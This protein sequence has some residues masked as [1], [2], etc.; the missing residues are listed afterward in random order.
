M[1]RAAILADAVD[2]IKELQ[3]QMKELKDEVRALEVQDREKNTPQPK[4]AAVNEQEGTRSSTLNQSSSDCTKKMPMEVERL[5][6][7]YCFL[8]ILDKTKFLYV[9]SVT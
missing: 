9:L 4:K 7:T 1:D 6:I 2:Y 8:L 3:T 5:S